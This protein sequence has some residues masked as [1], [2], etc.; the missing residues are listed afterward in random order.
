MLIT[1]IDKQRVA[2]EEIILRSADS[3]LN[4]VKLNGK[5]FLTIVMY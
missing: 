2:T 4:L 1:Y 5:L 3:L